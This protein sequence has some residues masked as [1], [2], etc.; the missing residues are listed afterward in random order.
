MRAFADRARF[1]GAGAAHCAARGRLAASLLYMLA[2]TLR[3]CHVFRICWSTRRLTLMSACCIYMQMITHIST[4]QKNIT[5]TRNTMVR[6][7]LNAWCFM[8]PS[9]THSSA[10]RAGPHVDLTWRHLAAG[11]CQGGEAAGGARGSQDSEPAAGQAAVPPVTF[12]YSHPCSLYVY[13]Q[14]SMLVLC[15]EF[16]PNHALL[17]RTWPTCELM[18]TVVSSKRKASR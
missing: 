11:G 13:F 9:P 10:E 18:T 6:L 16:T 4:K 15:P 17:T 8:C 1:H 7:I 12:P 14:S 5:C 3:A 2:Y